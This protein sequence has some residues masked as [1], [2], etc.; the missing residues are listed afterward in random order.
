[1][2]ADKAIDAISHTERREEP[3]SDS[4]AEANT[5]ESIEEEPEPHLH[6]K[7]WLIVA[8]SLYKRSLSRRIADKYPGRLLCLVCPIDTTGCSRRSRLSLETDV[9]VPLTRS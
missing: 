9:D 4:Q 5:F 1:M 8:V 2:Q 7:T 3:K 6:L